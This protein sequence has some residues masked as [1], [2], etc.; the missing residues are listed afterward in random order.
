VNATPP[1]RFGLIGTG[2]RSEYFARIAAALPEHVSIGAVTSRRPE[3]ANAFGRLWGLDVAADVD[4]LL[5]RD[6]DFV[7]VS[8]P[9]AIA[10][11]IIR[12]SVTAGKPVLTETPPAA[13]LDDLR[14]LYTAL[15]HDS[16]VQVAEQYQFQP[17][18]A[19]RID[20][21]RSGLI[22]PVSSTRVSAAHGYH[23]VSLI[24][25]LLG[26][27]FGDVTIRAAKVPDRLLTGNGRNGFASELTTATPARTVAQLDVVGADGQVSQSGL[28][29]FDDEQYFSP[30]RSR[31]VSVSG[32]NGEI[33]DLDVSRWVG[34]GHAITE[35][36][37]RDVMGIDGDLDGSTLRRLTLGERVLW[38][39]EFGDV[40][41]SDDE[42]AGA[43]ALV[44]MAAFARGGKSFYGLADGSHDH[45]LSLLIDE[46]AASGAILRS[47]PQPWSGQVSAA[48][49]R[50]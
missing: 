21:V 17:H 3:S 33:S 11:E 28:F 5:A 8:V 4:D 39:N 38:T 15:G 41:L 35:S 18:H 29:D 9:R 24:R 45:Y 40:R 25:L 19:A 42:L 12:A 7:L 46:A 30:I 14:E 32:E 22:G 1:A 13:G 34:P 2:W 43:R 37:A 44:R 16:P 23:G 27:G 50:L 31:H 10:P 36:I 6:L 48:A 20:L 26:V 49:A 47:E